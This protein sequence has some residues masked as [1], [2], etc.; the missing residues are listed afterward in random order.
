[1]SMKLSQQAKERGGNKARVIVTERVDD[2]ALL[3]GQRVTMGFPE[4]WDRPIP[5]HGTPRGRSWGWTATMWLAS[6]VTEG[7]H[8]QGSV[9]TSLTGMT[10]TLSQL[11]AQGSAPVAVRDDRLSHRL[12]PV[13]KPTSWPKIARALHARRMAVDAW[14]Q[15][16]LR[17]EATTVSGAHEGTAGGRWPWGQRKE[18]PT[19][20]QINVMPGSLAPWGRP[21]STAVWSGERADEGFDLPRS[22]RLRTG[23]TTSGRRCVGDGQRRA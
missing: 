22:A 17:W 15:E 3:L 5:R 8:R 14:S 19:R 11:S 7:D 18:D 6:S 1:M 21:R 13:R 16:V 4:V 23:C 10:H 9:A 2:V 12:Q 20:P